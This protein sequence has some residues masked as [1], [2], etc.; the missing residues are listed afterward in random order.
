[1]TALKIRVLGG[2]EGEID[3]RQRRIEVA[4]ELTAQVALGDREAIVGAVEGREVV[5]PIDMIALH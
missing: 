3:T 4:C 1:M 2:R 5:A